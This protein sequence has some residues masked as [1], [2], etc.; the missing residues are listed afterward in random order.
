MVEEVCQMVW[1]LR[2]VERESGSVS[3]AVR[4][5]KARENY[6]HGDCGDVYQYFGGDGVL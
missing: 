4:Q 3:A 6:R 2:A 1:D 5:C